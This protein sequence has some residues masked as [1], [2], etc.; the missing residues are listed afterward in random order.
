VKTSTKSTPCL[1]ERNC[2]RR[3]LGNAVTGRICLQLVVLQAVK[4]LQTVVSLWFA[5]RLFQASTKSC[6]HF[7][8]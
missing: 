5:D 4:R 8:F 1:K 3:H 6:A 7:H 2:S